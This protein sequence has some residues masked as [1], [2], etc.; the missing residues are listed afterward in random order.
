[1]GRKK[2]LCQGVAEAWGPVA[3]AAGRVDERAGVSTCWA[4]LLGRSLGRTSWA[5]LRA[6]Q[7]WLAG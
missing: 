6:K 5:S 3:A 4:S 1:M 7:G 2:T